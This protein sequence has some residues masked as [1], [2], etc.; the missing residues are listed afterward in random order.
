MLNFQTGAFLIPYFIV[1]ILI[2]YPLLLM[3]TALGQKY[4]SGAVAMWGQVSPYASGI[5]LCSL[6]VRNYAKKFRRVFVL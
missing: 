4:Q 5:G 6:I 1:L 3:E 2:G